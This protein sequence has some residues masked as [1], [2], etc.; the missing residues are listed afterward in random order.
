MKADRPVNLELST[1]SFP[2]TAIT[3]I[4]HRI[5]GIALFVGTAFIVWVLHQSLASP[6]AFATASEITSHWLS[7]LIIWGLLAALAYHLTAG[8][9]HLVMDLGIGETFEGGH[10]LSQA[11]VA[12]SVLLIVL[13][14]VWVW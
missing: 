13:A 12:V 7:K 3:S 9:K 8:V 14:G 10:R 1:I 2:L 11:T 5:S 4:L 6:E